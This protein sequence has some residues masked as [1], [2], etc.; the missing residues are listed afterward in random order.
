VTALRFHPAARIELDAARRHYRNKAPE[1]A[2]RFSSEVMRILERIA[3]HPAQFPEHGLLAVPTRLQTLFFSVRR[4]V[5]PR[6][7]PY[8]LFYYVREDGAVVLAVAHEKRRPGYWA[9]RA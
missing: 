1:V 2:R 5:L 9:H 3:Q 7:F 8:V 6:T 4:A